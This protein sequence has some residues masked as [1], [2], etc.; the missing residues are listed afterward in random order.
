MIAGDRQER[1]VDVLYLITELSVVGGAEKVLVRFLTH[2]DRRRFRPTV[3]CLYG[4]DGPMADDVRALGIP[5]IDLGMTAKWRLDALWRLY[6]LLRRKRPLILHAS[7]F[8]ANVLGRVLGRLAGVPIIVTW[9]HSVGIGWQGREWVNRWTALLNDKAIA[10]CELARRIEIQR[11]KV[12]SDRVV[13]VYNGLDVRRFSLVNPSSVVQIRHSLGVRSGALLL[14]AVGRLS[15]EKDYANLLAAMAKVQKHVPT[16]RL[17]IV[18]DGELRERLEIQAQSLGLSDVVTFTGIRDDVPEIL[19]AL[20]IFVL[21]SRREGLPLAVLEAM[22]AGLP[23]VAT[24]VGGVPEVVVDGVTGFLVP[25]L[26]PVALAEALLSLLQ[27]PAR[28]K[29][30]GRAGYKRVKQCFSMEQMTRQ[31][32]SLY[33]ELLVEKCR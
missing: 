21:S 4:G 5:V 26:N 31:I 24:V 11:T 27:D 1:L 7:M 22:A 33:E 8:H 16:A 29:A 10:V 2:L 15:P 6:Y 25:P 12:P 20:D 17:F 14:G 28:C 19:A 3:A 30:M 23:V 18:G 32:E 9:R 13:T